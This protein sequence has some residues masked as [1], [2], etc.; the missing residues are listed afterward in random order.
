VST[1]AAVETKVVELA[2]V[3]AAAKPAGPVVATVAEFLSAEVG[4]T[5]YQLTGVIE[6]TYNTQYGNF[7]LNDGT[8]E[9]VVYGLTATKVEKNDMSFASLG[10][11]DGD[12]VTLIGTRDVYKETPQVGGPAYYV[13]HVAAP[14]LDLAATTAT[15][16]AEATEYMIA[17]ESNTTWT[18]VASE[19]VTLDK[20]DGEGSAEVTMTVAANTTNDAIAHTVTFTY[21]EETATFT[22][23]QKGVPAPGEPVIIFKETF[24]KCTGTMGWSGSVANGTFATDNENWTAVNAYGADGAAK[25]GASG[26][27]GTAETPVLNITGTATLKFKAGAWSGDATTLKLSMTNGTLS[28]TSVTMKSGDWTEYE[29]TITN[30]TEGAKIKFEG[31]QASKARFFLDDIVIT[32]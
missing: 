19:G 32:Q 23:T 5:E 1:E 27:L 31:K 11:R 25:F 29:I 28:A 22:L 24:A 20:T 21:G 6:R 15:I 17:F 26:K 16:D 18:A 4:D 9:V 13:S 12:T 8:A 2:Y 7:Y 10:L 3:Q 30:A 14:F